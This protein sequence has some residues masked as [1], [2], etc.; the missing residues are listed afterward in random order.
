MNVWILKLNQNKV[1]VNIFFSLIII[2][3]KLLIELRKWYINSEICVVES[4]IS[5]AWVLVYPINEKYVL[6][7][8]DFAYEQLRAV[9]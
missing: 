9:H 3:F 1:N 8:A 2:R 5:I 4:E 7:T 6:N